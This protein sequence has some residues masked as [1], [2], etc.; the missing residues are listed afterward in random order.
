LGGWW[1]VIRIWSMGGC[2][3]HGKTNVVRRRQEWFRL[4]SWQKW[5]HISVFSIQIW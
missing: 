1:S 2:F 3:C 4:G 5:Q